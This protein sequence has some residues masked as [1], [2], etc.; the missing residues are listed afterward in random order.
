MIVTL[1]GPAG[2]GK[3]TAARALAQRLGVRYL[4]TGAMFRAYTLRA[5]EESTEL[6]DEAALI[7]LVKRGGF[8]MADNGTVRLGARDVSEEIRRPTVT[9]AIRF[10]ANS[11]PVRRP[12]L[13]QQR[14]LARDWQSLVCDGRDTGTVVFPRAEVK[15]YLDARVEVRAAR[16]HSELLKRG[17]TAPPV[18]ELA[19]QI[20]DRDESD[21]GR[22]VAPLK[23]AEDAIVV[24]TSDLDLEQVVNQLHSIVVSRRQ[25]GPV[26]EQ[27]GTEV[28]CE[29]S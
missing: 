11:G 20:R 27:S 4:D 5:L 29:A 17:E 7:G 21:K 6:S 24:D 10:L 8:D 3:S 12:I 16:R 15:F 18:E 13:E 26:P 14:A 22:A 23:Q 9:A 2:A 28:D 1:D 19:A 25:G